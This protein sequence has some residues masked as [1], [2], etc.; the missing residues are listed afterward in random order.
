MPYRLTSKQTRAVGSSVPRVIYEQVFRSDVWDRGTP[1]ASEPRFGGSEAGADKRALAHHAYTSAVAAH[2]QTRVTDVPPHVAILLAKGDGD[3][4]MVVGSKARV[5]VSNAEMDALPM[6][7][8]WIYVVEPVASVAT[9]VC[10]GGGARTTVL[11]KARRHAAFHEFFRVR[12]D[13]TGFFDAQ[14]LER[15]SSLPAL[16][17][18]LASPSNSLFV[19]GGVAEETSSPLLDYVGVRPPA[20]ALQRLRDFVMPYVTVAHLLE[21]RYEALQGVAR[22]ARDNTEVIGSIRTSGTARQ[23]FEASSITLFQGLRDNDPHL[24]HCADIVSYWAMREYIIDTLP[25]DGPVRRWFAEHEAQLVLLR[26]SLTHADA[27][28]RTDLLVPVAETFGM[29]RDPTTG[30]YSMNIV[31]ALAEG[32]RLGA[33]KGLVRTEA[34][35][36]RAVLTEDYVASHVMAAWIAR[37]VVGDLPGLEDENTPREKEEDVE[38]RAA[39]KRIVEDRLDAVQRGQSGLHLPSASA[40][41]RELPDIED[42]GAASAL[43][44]P[45]AFALEEK[46]RTTGHLKFGERVAHASF[47]LDLNYPKDTVEAHMRKHFSSVGGT[48][49][50]DFTS[51]YAGSVHRN[52]CNKW[53]N[54]VRTVP[55]GMACRRLIARTNIA[56]DNRANTD[57]RLGCPF[58]RFESRA[59]M[60]AQLLRMGIADADAIAYTA[61][62]EGNCQKACAETFVA[63]FGRVPSAT[64]RPRAPRTYYQEGRAIVV[65]ALSEDTQ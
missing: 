20:A 46:L 42:F 55:Y 58:Q 23:V 3:S 65:E 37:A 60:S 1:Q 43:F 63:K 41:P 49:D 36:H 47:L 2:T 25:H 34:A 27:D 16:P 10:V 64:W 39:A 30:T 48:P 21:R 26:T 4:T 24:Q 53:E 28:S 51:K 13:S 38:V 22:F 61:R 35:T 11:S 50:D 33:G 31:D 44:P 9:M 7:K 8:T 14:T 6:N 57:L 45:C 18:A 17:P 5:R 32:I 29:V 56:G 54:G 62:V 19:S 52:E 15:E 12:L 40:D 59:D